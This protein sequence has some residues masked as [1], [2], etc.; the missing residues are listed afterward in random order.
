M[1]YFFAIMAFF[2]LAY[3]A[4]AEENLLLSSQ[5]GTVKT[6]FELSEEVYLEGTCAAAN[7]EPG[8]IYIAPDKNWVG[9]EDLSD[10]SGGI[11]TISADTDGKF[12]RIKIWRAPLEGK[13]DVVIDTNNNY[14]L[15]VYEL[16]CVIG[17][18]TTGFSVGNPPAPA[19]VVTT[20][21]PPPPAPD[22][23]PVPAAAS[24]ARGRH[25]LTRPA[26]RL[27]ASASR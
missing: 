7:Q 21:P 26:G 9:G 10:I 25:T 20:P 22:P 16:Q 24:A 11:E 19:P 13:Y 18:N 14:K 23:A 8:K 6:Q 27:K 12:S 3:P 17:A 15:E 2:L 1:K 5:S 4:F